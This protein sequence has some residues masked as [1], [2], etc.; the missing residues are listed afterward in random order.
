MKFGFNT[1]WTR[2]TDSQRQGRTKGINLKGIRHSCYMYNNI[3]AT[4]IQIKN[5]Y[6]S[7][8]SREKTVAE[9]RDVE[10]YSLKTMTF[11]KVNGKEIF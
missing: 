7:L 10:H 1:E 5:G 8:F 11:I 2:F 6:K 9:Q 3:G 4:R